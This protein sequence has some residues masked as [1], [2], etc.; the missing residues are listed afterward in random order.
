MPQARTFPIAPTAGTARIDDELVLK[1]TPPRLSRHLLNRPRLLAD[2]E[3]WR[4]A[5]VVLVQAPAGYGKTSLLAQ[6]R[7]E[8]LAQGHVVAWLTAQ[9]RD[10]PQRLLQA[11][12]LSVRNASGR[13]TFGHTL[14]E[15][16]ASG[17]L[18]GYTRWLASV[19][20]LAMSVVLV[21]DEIERLPAASLDRLT[22]LLHNAP[23][24]LRVLVA[25]RSEVDLA[26]GDLITYGQCVLLGSHALALQL[27]ETLEV[28]RQRFPARVDY[29]L[30]ARLHE[31]IDGWPLGLQL[32]LSLLA[33]ST[34]R[35]AAVGALAQ[36][37]GG[38]RDELVGL[39]LANLDPADRDFLVRIA[40]LDR[41]H[42]D[43]CRAVVGADD[44]GE[45]LTRLMRDT[46]VFVGAEQGEWLRMHHLARDQLRLRCAELPAAE[47]AGLHGR[48]SDWLAHQG[49]IE[50]AAWHALA[51]G[52]Q[53]RAYQLAERSLYE[54]ILTRG[55]QATVF[56]WLERLP[57]AELE[58]RPRLLLAAAWSLA[59]SERHAEAVRL[60]EHLH[61][62][63]GIAPELQ[64]ECALILGGAAVFADQP[65]RYAELHDP[66]A[67]LPL[68]DPLLR[69]VQANRNAFRA[70]IGGDPALARMRQQMAPRDDL[71]SALAHVAR[72]G[73]FIVG[74]SYLWE[75]QVR[76]AENLL[77]PT[78]QG[79]EGELGRR[80]SFACMLAALLAAAVCER[81]RPAEAAALLANRL[82]V[83]ERSGLPETVLLGYRTAARV[84]MAEGAED[85]AIELLGAMHA[86]GV[87]R[88]LPRL[89]LVSLVEQLRIHARGYRA[90]TCRALLVQVEAFFDEPG[91]PDGRLWRR[92][93]E[94]LRH[95]AHALA[96]IGA[97]EWRRAVAPIDCAEALVRELRLGRQ[98]IELLALRAFV[99]DRC[100]ED[101]REQL[102]E[103][104][105]LADAM[106]LGRVFIDAHPDLDAWARRSVESWG[107]RSAAGSAAGATH[108]P[109]PAARETPA[110]RAAPS[111]ALTPKER[112][113]LELLAR[114]LSNK[115][116]G[117]ALQVGEETI[118]WHVKNLFA[119]LDA[120]TR[121]QVVLRARILG[122]F[123]QAA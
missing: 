29:D 117:L 74:L 121:K 9:G 77:R 69:F 8:H 76:L 97:Q 45:R 96:A 83:L 18:E 42:P 25:A 7:R 106:G 52:E 80:S 92:S 120:G 116:I 3:R 66:W 114:N 91:L 101:S 54:S 35:V 5:P 78:L 118:K 71:G 20:Q 113:M 31:L 70:L 102:R 112:E 30:A 48:A 67:D 16:V 123:E 36:H 103:V 6:W 10:D 32:A 39:L 41:L 95:V 17:E 15:S 2:D 60:I 13:P 98:Q 72:W 14:L 46:P 84:A 81:G 99:L 122:L 94:L 56:E 4:D 90:A 11:L 49:L 19:A 75:G 57:R 62:Q 100:G 47:L 87:T 105:D 93:V 53:E 43:L 21:L 40:V 23:P 63:P 37:G 61:G 79:A 22:Y 59:L 108:A 110:L 86:V 51:A 107:A 44:A 119:K 12:A 88:H 64:C 24:N 115:E 104:V 58:R 85:R 34:D 27:D 109:R 28:V 55:R 82:D 68:R 73:D 26:L 38:L 111:M 33:R 50:A 89:R 65:D 1:V